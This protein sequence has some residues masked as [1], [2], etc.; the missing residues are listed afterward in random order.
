[1]NREELKDLAAAYA[2]GGLDGEDR[3]LEQPA[4]HIPAQFAEEAQ[5]LRIQ[6]GLVQAVKAYEELAIA[7]A[8]LR[9][10]RFIDSPL[11]DVL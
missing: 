10:A 4:E 8:K 3:E 7:A 11:R 2:L 9:T 5:V 1:M 6:R